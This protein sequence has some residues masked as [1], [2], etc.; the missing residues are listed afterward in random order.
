MPKAVK[1][2][3]STDKGIVE[4][5]GGL[6]QSDKIKGV[7][8]LKKMNE[9]GAVAYSLITEVDELEKAVPFY[10]FMPMNAGRALST[11]TLDGETQEPIAAVLRPCEIRAF[12][13][14]V[15]RAQGSLENFLLISPVCAGVFPLKSLADGSLEKNLSRYWESVENA[16]LDP[17][18]RETCQSCEDF[19][20][21]H[22][23]MT[24]V[25]VGAKN[26]EEGCI[27]ILNTK[28]AEEFASGVTGQTVSEETETEGTEKLKKLRREWKETV[29][30]EFERN[31]VGQAALIKTFAACLG[32][33]ACSHACPICYCTFCDF[34]SKTCEYQPVSFHSELEQKGGLK[35]P[36]G[37]IFFHLGRMAHMAVSCVRCGMCSDVCPVGI[38]VASVFSRVGDSLQ[39][40]FEYIPGRNVEEPVPSGTYKEQ[41]FVEIGEQ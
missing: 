31:G 39:E 32:C 16:A 3:N 33:H 29:F 2:K 37:N 24:I 5:L 27:V 12:I 28:K 6:L 14:L 36:P 35:V 26:L 22:A 34:D 17:N 38:P 13:E 23:D 7:F 15:K 19:I 10:P 18:T 9:S 21:V 20:P 41:E 40:V 30:E 25:T 11:F 1:I 8:T 4:M